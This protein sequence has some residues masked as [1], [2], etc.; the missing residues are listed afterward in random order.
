MDPTMQQAVSEPTQESPD[1]APL[2]TNVNATSEA[3]PADSG[4]AEKTLTSAPM[5]TYDQSFPSLGGPG[6]GGDGA[7]PATPFGR[8]NAKPRV[9]SS[10]IT[11]VCFCGHKTMKMGIFFCTKAFILFLGM[12]IALI[13]RGSCYF[14]S[15]PKYHSCVVLL[16]CS[17]HLSIMC[18]GVPYS[19]GGKEGPGRIRQRC[20]QEIDQ[21]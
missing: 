18:T 15:T 11:Q 5:P 21:C 8:W 16:Q 10:T 13:K 2:E 19:G 20:Q 1:P 17:V 12:S 6:A 9:Q 3:A 14:K 7:A 4:E